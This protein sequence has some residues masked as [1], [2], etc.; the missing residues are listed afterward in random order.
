MRLT[1]RS[2]DN[3]VTPDKDTFLWDDEIKGF[4]LR[5]SPQG[6]KT[7][8]VQYRHNGRTQR[9]RLGHVGNLTIHKARRDAQILIGEIANGKSPAKTVRNFRESPTLEDV[10][11]RFINEHVKLKLKPSTQSDYQ[12]NIRKY[13]LPSLGKRKIA[14]IQYQDIHALHLKMKDIPTQAN[15]T[16]SL[17]S[18]IFSL[19]ERWGLREGSSNPCTQIE[20]YKE[21]RRIRFLDKN[22]LSKLW[23]TL[24]TA[25]AKNLT[26]IYAVTA[27]KLLI[28]TGCRL[29]EI[30]TLKWNYIKG[31][32]ID[33][34]DSKTGHKRIP[35][36]A[37]AMDVLQQTP[38]KMDNEYVICGDV[39]GQPIINLQKSWRR[40]RRE[41][42]LDD[43]RIHDLRHTFA[44]HAVMG[45]TPLALV[46]KLLGHTQIS[47]TM[48]YAHLADAELAKASEGIGSILI[49]E[50]V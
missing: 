32:R 30:R 28:L 35:L 26:S 4:G 33:F 49:N 38:R 14:E 48:R 6:K 5:L 20:R 24:E 37:A 39:C 31:N 1:K 16:V 3:L 25:H 50:S 22:E 13:I 18:K 17:L 46:S 15:R 44:S 40:I 41:A 43:V 45:G 8:I 2:I 34:P 9:I 42:G 21:K 19:S 23:E 47:T 7:F 27:Y 29:G 12:H 36:N 11:K 10:S